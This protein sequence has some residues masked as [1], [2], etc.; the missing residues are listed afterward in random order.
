M[1]TRSVPGIG[2]AAAVS[3]GLGGIAGHLFGHGLTPWV[4]ATVA[5]VFALMIDRNL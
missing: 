4:A 5:G 2:G 3:A 1:A